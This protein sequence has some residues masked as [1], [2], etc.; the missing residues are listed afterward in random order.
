M[1]TKKTT[2]ERAHIEPDAP[3]GRVPAGKDRDPGELEDHQIRKVLDVLMCHAG[4]NGSSAAPPDLGDPHDSLIFRSGVG[5]GSSANAFDLHPADAPIDAKPPTITGY[6]QLEAIRTGGQGVVFRAIQR[7]TGRTVA[8][9]LTRAAGWQSDWQRQRFAREVAL[10]S[11]L[12]HPHIVTIFDS[13]DADGRLYFVMEYVDGAAID[14]FAQIRKLSIRD[15]ARL[16]VQVCR[17]VQY[18]HRNGIIHRD[19]KPSNILVDKEGRPHILDFGLAKDLISPA[20]VNPADAP[21]MSGQVVGTLPYL[22]PEQAAGRSRDAD[23][24]ADVYTLGVILFQLL[25][26]QFPYSVIGHPDEVRANIIGRPP[27]PLRRALANM[28]IVA[29]RGDATLLAELEAVLLRTLEKNPDRRYQSV[30]ELADDLERC[31]A[32]EP[33]QARQHDRW[34]LLRRTLRAYR[35]HVIVAAAFALVLLVAAAGVFVA[36]RRADAAWRRSDAAWQ[37]SER[38]AQIATDGLNMGSFIRLASV[39]RDSKRVYDAVALYEKALEIGARGATD[40]PVVVRMALEAYYQ[41]GQVHTLYLQSNYLDFYKA[42]ESIQR[43]MSLSERLLQLAPNDSMSSYWRAKVLSL[44]GYECNE[45]KAWAEGFPALIGAQEIFSRLRAESPDN[46]LFSSDMADV[47]ANMGVCLGR[48]GLTE[49]QY[50]AYCTSMDLHTEVVFRDPRD[51]DTQL[52]RCND[53][54]NLSAW[55]IKRKT[56]ADYHAALDYTS[57]AERRISELGAAGMLTTRQDQSG[58]ILGYVR[59][60][61]ALALQLLRQLGAT[62]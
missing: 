23:I 62:E 1:Q 33:V 26:R 9:K 21:S 2:T 34:F 8:I 3:P 27:I 39:A 12:N 45:R 32:G 41:L 16:M 49:E 44:Q 25:S 15:S 55:H 13:G 30:G 7:S 52:S 35:T 56:P 10:T 57:G 43:A 38:V 58:R 29:P 11:R 40:D 19:L 48:F 46:S 36:W 14:E 28:S 50:Q 54:V 6:D 31:L 20:P 24:R 22:S 60:N 17:A 47:M 53:A 61:H 59:K 18:A 4:G 5:T 51:V 42:G 37:R